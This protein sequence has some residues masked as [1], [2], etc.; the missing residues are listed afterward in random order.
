MEV[1]YKLMTKLTYSWTHASK[2][3]GLDEIRANIN[4][5]I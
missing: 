3:I 2:Q 4:K 1:I 5:N